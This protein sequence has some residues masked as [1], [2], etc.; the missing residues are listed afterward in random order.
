MTIALLVNAAL[1][2]LAKTRPAD[3]LSYAN[4]LKETE[5]WSLD[6]LSLS[7]HPEAHV[8][9]A[10]HRNDEPATTLT[11]PFDLQR[12]RFRRALD[13][14]LLRWIADGFPHS[15]RLSVGEGHLIVAWLPCGL[16]AHADL[17]E[18]IARAILP[19]PLYDPWWYGKRK[20]KSSK[21]LHDE[22]VMT[23]FDEVA[24]LHAALCLHAAG[25]IRPSV[26]L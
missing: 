8:I 18:S 15:V 16:L 9:R 4:Q 19:A 25:Y 17:D 1:A 7:I 24:E 13:R 5:G 10:A 11:L 21:Q 23:A 6:G 12:R 14:Q 22:E 2:R 26:Q 20:R 3:A